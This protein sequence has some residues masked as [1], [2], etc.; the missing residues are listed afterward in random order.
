MWETMQVVLP[1]IKVCAI[2]CW[3]IAPRLS[4]VMKV[5]LTSNTSITSFDENI[6]QTKKK[7]QSISTLLLKSAKESIK[8]KRIYC[9]S[10]IKL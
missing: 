1:N 3:T 2:S 6:R 4:G 8:P 10:R 9:I 5:F 7:N